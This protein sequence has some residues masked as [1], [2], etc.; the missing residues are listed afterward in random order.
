MKQIK[1]VRLSTG[2][3]GTFGVLLMQGRLVCYTLEPQKLGNEKNVSCIPTGQYYCHLYK[4]GK[5]GY[6]Y[7]VSDVSN[8]DGILFHSGNTTNDT[9]G[10]ILLGNRLGFLDS[11]PAVLG[12]KD[13]MKLFLGILEDN[14]DNFNLTVVEYF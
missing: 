5:Y 13:T 10:C 6:T 1:I 11:I 9:R 2:R 3:D 12:S 8:R 14:K 4:S 7:K